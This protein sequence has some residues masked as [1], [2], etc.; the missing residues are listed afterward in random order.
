[1]LN[2]IDLRGKITLT[3]NI[4]DWLLKGSS[5][6]ISVKT[7]ILNITL[8][9]IF[10]EAAAAVLKGT[11]LFWGTVLLSPL[12]FWNFVRVST[13]WREK[14]S[15]RVLFSIGMTVFLG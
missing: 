7:Q 4:G 13:M 11:V 2:H 6:S 8:H 9:V 15:F 10:K 12:G 5:E 14:H 3:T 1:M